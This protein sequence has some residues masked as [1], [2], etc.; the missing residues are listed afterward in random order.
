MP[1]T[2]VSPPKSDEYAAYY[3]RYIQ[4]VARAIR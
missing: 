4:T 3:Q 1:E 2:I